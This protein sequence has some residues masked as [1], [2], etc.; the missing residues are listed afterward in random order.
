V[1]LAEELLDHAA[2]LL[3]REPGQTVP[4]VDVRRAVSASYYA[5]FHL[6]SAAVS[7][8]LSPSLPVGLR[9]RTQ[10]ALEHKVMKNAMEAFASPDA[11]ARLPRDLG[12]RE[13]F[14]L[15]LS[16]VAKAFSKL[17][18]ARYIA[19]YDVLDGDG[20]VGLT[21]GTENLKVAQEVF[22]T[23]NSVKAS[24]N[25]KVFL[26]ALILGSNWKK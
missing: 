18:E 23:W 4:G 9:G 24:E 5:I 19:D 6:L 21:W 25:A 17:Q 3:N 12:I 16:R 26:A 8:Q 20:V 1:P 22:A 10:R 13:P 14:S 7:E 15:D 2:W 11:F